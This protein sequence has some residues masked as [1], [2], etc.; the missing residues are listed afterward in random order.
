VIIAD[1]AHHESHGFLIF[2]IAVHEH[3]FASAPDARPRS[4]LATMT[5][6]VGEPRC[7][8]K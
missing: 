5:G 1:A 8:E 7:T 3:M 2:G 4:G 6:W